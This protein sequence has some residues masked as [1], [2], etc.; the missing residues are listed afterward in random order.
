M[1]L[2]SNVTLDTAGMDS[3][4]AKLPG[5]MA[6]ATQFSAD[7][8][9]PIAEANIDDMGAVDTGALRES[10]YVAVRGGSNYAE[11]VAAAEQ[12]YEFN[13]TKYPSIRQATGG[14]LQVDPP[15]S[16]RKPHEA[17]LGVAASHGKAVEEGYVS[18]FGNDVEPRPFMSQTARDGFPGVVQEFVRGVQRA[19]K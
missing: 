8:L 9:R 10:L 3:L 4:I 16:A 6:V 15:V 18:I 12:A 14:V 13:P 2:T 1:T 11:S 5:E 17:Y 19:L 7:L